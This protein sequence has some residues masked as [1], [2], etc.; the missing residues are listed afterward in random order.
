MEGKLTLALGGGDIGAESEASGV[1]R[2]EFAYG[3]KASDVRMVRHTLTSAVPK[4]FITSEWKAS[5]VVVPK[6]SRIS[7]E[8]PANLGPFS[9]YSISTGL[10]A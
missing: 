2:E 6:G 10:M 1:Q 5:H 7:G 9:R 3:Y 8:R 4:K